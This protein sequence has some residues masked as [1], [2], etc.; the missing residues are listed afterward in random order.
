MVEFL[1][2]VKEASI[3]GVDQNPS[4][5]HANRKIPY[6]RWCSVYKLVTCVSQKLLAIQRKKECVTSDTRHFRLKAIHEMPRHFT[7]CLGISA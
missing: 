1:N 6:D 5:L 4:P 3:S 7:K 2:D